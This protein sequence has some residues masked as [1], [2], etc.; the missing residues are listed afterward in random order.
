MAAPSSNPDPN[1]VLV[2]P[3]PATASVERLRRQALRLL[4]ESHEEAG[5]APPRPS[6]TQGSEDESPSGAAPAVIAGFFAMPAVF[7]AIV[8]VALALFGKPGEAAP[9][10][11]DAARFPEAAPP[12]SSAR[13][14]DAAPAE[15][16]GV[17]T[18]PDEARIQSIA[19]DG[20]RV[21]LEIEGPAGREIVVYDLRN[22]RRIASAAIESLSI[23]AS[24]TLS[25]LTG[26]PPAAPSAPAPEPAAP[27]PAYRVGP[28]LKPR[29]AE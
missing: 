29:S 27:L 6:A 16:R 15:T 26:P 17:I 28:R 4:T 21:A 25:M 3:D 18:L 12:P 14:P 23:E 22:G 5:A 10:R 2:A 13:L 1:F 20:D 8:F 11:A 19:L 7:L 24:D 9:V